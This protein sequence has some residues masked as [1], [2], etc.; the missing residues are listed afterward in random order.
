MDDETIAAL[1]TPFGKGGIAVLRVS[2]ANVLSIL[3]VIIEKLPKQ[4]VPQ[5]AYHG[6]V[7]KN[8]QRVDECVFVFFK[9][10][11]SYSGEDL[12]EISIHSNP[13]IIEEVLNF[14]FKSGAR[15]AMPG[16]FTYR[17]FKN[18]K[19]DLIQA[20]S[21]NEL[22]NANSK[23]F[24]F[25]KFDSVEGKLSN[26]IK[27]VRNNLLDLGIKVETVIEFQEDQFLEPIYMTKEIDETIKML[28]QILSHSGLNEVLNKGLNIVIIGKVNVGKSSLFNTLLM[29]ER[30][31]ISHTPGTTRDFIKEKLYVDGFPFEIIDIAGINTKT[32][33]AIESEGIKRGYQRVEDSDAVIF[34]LDASVPLDELD[35]EIYNRIIKRKKILVA[36]KMDIVNP[37]VLQQIKSSFNDENIYEISAKEGINVDGIFDFF[38]TLRKMNVNKNIH[39]SLN[40]RQKNLLDTLVDIL[41]K[42]KEICRT[43][44]TGGSVYVQNTEIIAEEIRMGI[45]IIAQLTGEISTQ[46]IING[47]F[48]KFCIGK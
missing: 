19:M 33:S 48:S 12:A 3:A 8:G 10:P 18:G 39:F 27:G 43:A 30:A 34:M 28:E 35:F 11:H 24:A 16:E 1:S 17:A 45:D 14:I 2:G 9:K 15:Q 32:V 31:I 29:E 38:K 47:I 26:L 37:E 6:F 44:T 23:Y 4:I 13:F 5:K 40:Q 22:I 7:V 36:N 21:I 41:K 20:E 25:L 42:I 46:E